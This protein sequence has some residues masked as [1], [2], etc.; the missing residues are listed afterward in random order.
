[1]Q[2]LH[3]VPWSKSDNSL[4]LSPLPRPTIPQSNSV[5]AFTPNDRNENPFEDDFQKGDCLAS[6]TSPSLRSQQ[7]VNRSLEL[8]LPPSPVHQAHGQSVRPQYIRR[9]SHDLFEYIEQCPSKRLSED[10]ARYIF[11]QVVDIVDYL[12][13]EGVS[14]R[15]IKD[16]NLIIDA[17]LKVIVFIFPHTGTHSFFIL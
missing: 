3:G 11:A 9:P 1:M 2:E 4:L 7:E 15:D 8:L 12:D 17:Q 14:H 5:S 13:G 10:D 6:P 16:E